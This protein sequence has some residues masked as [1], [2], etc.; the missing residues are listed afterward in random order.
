MICVAVAART[1]GEL[2]EEVEKVRDEAD[3]I[4]VRADLLERYDSLGELAR[5]GDRLVVTVRRREEGGAFRGSEE[6]RLRLYRELI[7]LRPRLVDVELFSQIAPMVVEAAR[8]AESSV[9]LSYHDFEG[10]P[11]VDALEGIREEALRRGADVVKVATFARRVEDNLTVLQ[12]LLRSRTPTVA[13]CMGPLGKVSRAL[14][15][16]FGGLF[17]FACASKGKET[18]PGQLTIDELRSVWRVLR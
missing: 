15:P 7:K 11:S 12:F 17:T 16:L 9:M 8:S 14:S 18:A 2:L 13:F 4:E 1:V 3:L 5:Y 10:T 6:E